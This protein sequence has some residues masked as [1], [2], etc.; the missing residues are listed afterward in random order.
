MSLKLHSLNQGMIVLKCQRPEDEAIH[1]LILAY[2]KHCNP[3][4][5]I[6]FPLRLIQGNYDMY[7]HKP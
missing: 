7:S 5:G 4:V 2:P 1:V 3:I 6:P